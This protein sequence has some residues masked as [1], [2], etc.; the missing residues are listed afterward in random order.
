MKNNL[1]NIILK[2]NKKPVKAWK[3][4]IVSLFLFFAL[5]GS[6]IAIYGAG[7]YRFLVLIL[8]E[9][10]LEAM[11]DLPE[12]SRIYDRNGVLLYEV[13]GDVKRRIVPLD[14]VP[15]ALREA[16]I[17][18]E[19][20][21]FYRHRGFDVFGIARAFYK[22]FRNKKIRQG[23]S[24][25]TQQLARTV[26]LENDRVY[27]RKIKELV[28]AIEIEKRYSKDQIL[29]MYL[30]SIPY[31]ANAYGV[32]AA[33]EIYYGK[34]VKDLNFVE[35]VYLASLPKAPSD[36]NPF[37]PNQDLLVRRAESV[38]AAMRKNGFLIDYEQKLFLEKGRPDFVKSPVMIRA[39]HF[40]F[41]VLDELKKAYGE[42]YIREGGLDIYT[43][44][45]MDLQLSAENA[46]QKWGETNE[47][48][49]GADNS[50]LVALDPKT[51]QVLA[52]VGSRN[53]FASADGN[54]NAATSPRQP[55]SSFKPYVYAAAL[56]SGLTPNTVF[57]DDETDFAS[58]NS[59]VSYIP[60]N[61]SGKHYGAVTMRK[62]L[63]GSLNIPAVKAIV[64][65]GIGKVIDLAEN[66]GIST[67]AE[68]KR[69]GPSLALGGGEVKLIEH[70]SAMAV[71]GN[72]GIRQEI[73]PILKI[74]GRERKILYEWHLE[75]GRQ[76]VHPHAAYWINS[77]LSDTQARQYIFGRNNLLQFSGRQVAAK[78]G[79]SQDFRDAWTIGYAPNMAA[80]VWVGNSDNSPMKKGADGSKAAAPIWNEFMKYA[81]ARLPKEDFNRPKDIREPAPPKYPVELAA[82]STPDNLAKAVA[83]KAE[84]AR[85]MSDAL[86]TQPKS[87]SPSASVKALA[88]VA[89]AKPASSISVQPEK[90]AATAPVAPVL[91]VGGPDPSADLGG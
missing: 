38:I 52:M 13:H 10:K 8:P 33:S 42:S 24:T 36:Y 37:G 17:A 26:F 64:Q 34:N 54:F 74:S 66:M 6:S 55:G 27:S 1:Q 12:S 70:A 63:A 14:D 23:A 89:E 19:D 3:W 57:V 69:F 5:S 75:K 80:G 78:T 22:N 61:Y 62:A 49:Y 39:P 58:Y 50:A 4:M 11:L 82:S 45:D 51:G 60:R 20:K 83:P 48:K 91:E 16:T 77:I 81:L 40:V 56:S 31:G 65:T 59:G 88:V 47:K 43:S 28:L 72:N 30:N 32:S 86:G 87:V 2:K 84:E 25:I 9:P 79:T 35:C 68:R 29:E 53:Y 21:N 15:M 71:F 90:K 85:K 7:V 18:I 41:Y 76:A 67:L 46:V 73:S 44:L